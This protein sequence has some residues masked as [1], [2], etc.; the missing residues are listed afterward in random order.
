MNIFRFRF[1]AMK[2]NC[3]VVLVAESKNKGQAIAAHAIAEVSRIERIYSRY[4]PESIVSRINAAAGKDSVSC[5]SETITLLQYADK[6][7]ETSSGLF[8]ITSGVLRKA[9]NFS[10][11]ALPSPETLTSLLPL[12]DWKRVEQKDDRVQL[13]V[14]GMELDFGGFGKEYAADRAA[15][16]IHGKGVRSGYVNLAGDIRVI[17]PKPDGTAWVIGIQDPRHREKTIASIP[18]FSGALATSGDYER[19]FE[20]DG[21]R[22]CHIIH[23]RT[24]YPVTYWRSVTVVAPLAITAGSY[25]TIAMLK[26]D[27]GLAFLKDSGMDYLAVDK[28]GRIYHNN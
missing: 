25:S 6:L 24:G 16:V 19:F 28:F 7:Y 10:E 20:A 22:Y 21:K 2:S 17:G 11:A 4:R 15:A 8:D 3:E 26:E 9:W 27:D 13:P 18:L 1:Q 12:I 23:P 14:A 5:D